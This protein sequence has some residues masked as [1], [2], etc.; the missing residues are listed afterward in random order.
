VCFDAPLLSVQ[1]SACTSYDADSFAAAVAARGGG[2]FFVL[3]RHH[4]DRRDAE[5]IVVGFHDVQEKVV[6]GHH[7][8]ERLYPPP[9]PSR[10]PGRHITQRRSPI[11]SMQ[12][13]DSGNYTTAQNRSK[14][15]ETTIPDF[16]WKTNVSGKVRH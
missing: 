10:G 5:L 12:F 9:P 8:A 7:I 15:G 13:S 1:L 11:K 6:I 14:S 3:S 4:C 16:H 2:G